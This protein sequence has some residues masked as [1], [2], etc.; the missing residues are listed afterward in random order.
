MTRKGIDVDEYDWRDYLRAMTLGPLNGY[1][2]IGD[3]AEG[4]VDSLF[5][6]KN[7]MSTP[8]PVF[9]TARELEE[10]GRRVNKMIK[11]GEITTDDIVVVAD[12]VAEAISTA[13]GGIYAPARGTA[14][15]V[16]KL[17]ED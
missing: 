8:T 5:M 1:F 14:R 11:N 3:I 2:M 10:S 7:F 4:L 12:S 9:D 16:Q 6:G 15:K 17:L 13:R